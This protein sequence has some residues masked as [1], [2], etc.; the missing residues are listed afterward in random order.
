M[1]Q[2][3]PQ[4]QL[5][6]CE[7]LC[8]CDPGRSLQAAWCDL[9]AE[10]FQLSSESHNNL[11]STRHQGFF[12]CF[13]LR[14]PNFGGSQSNVCNTPNAHLCSNYY[15]FFPWRAISRLLQWATMITGMPNFNPNEPKRAPEIQPLSIFFYFLFSQVVPGSPVCLYPSTRACKINRCPSRGVVPWLLFVR[16]QGSL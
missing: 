10:S 12:T 3:K 2:N 14:V 9:R 4:S 15:R 7:T 13:E 1:I 5:P 8:W 16:T 11:T 6:T